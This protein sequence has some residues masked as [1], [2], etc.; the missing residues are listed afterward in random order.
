M[1]IVRVN[2]EQQ[3]KVRRQLLN[4]V[5]YIISHEALK[6][7]AQDGHTGLTPAEVFLSAQRFCNAM[8]E[9]PDI[10]EGIDDEMDGL[11]EEAVGENDAMFILIVATLQMQAMSKQHVGIDFKKAI[12]K[13]Y[14]RYG[15]HEL[16]FPLMDQFTNKEE[17]RWFEGKKTD[18]LNYELQEIW[19]EEGEAEDV[20]LIDELVDH[21]VEY[22]EEAIKSHILIVND[23]NQQHDNKFVRQEQRLKDALKETIK[24]KYEPTSIN[25]AQAQDIVTDKGIKI[26]RNF[27]GSI[28]E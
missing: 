5:V 27:N 24:R 28:E 16:L 7:M 15:D 8:L 26:V 14:E 13:V 18:L 4:D 21:A 22:G 11:E 12:Q 20:L 23:L 6:R 25:I 3:G 2:K 10:G 17:A 9:L 1:I 19:R